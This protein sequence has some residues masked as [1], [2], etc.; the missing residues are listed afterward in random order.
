M[1][2]YYEAPELDVLALRP[3]DVVTLSLGISSE[4]D[5]NVD[6]LSGERSQAWRYE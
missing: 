5:G 1:K 2:K 4:D 6:N 3:S